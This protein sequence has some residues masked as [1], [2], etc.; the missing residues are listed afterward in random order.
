MVTATASEKRIVIRMGSQTL[1][2]R[3]ISVKVFVGAMK[4]STT[5]SIWLNPAPAACPSTTALSLIGAILASKIE[6]F[7]LA[8]DPAAPGTENLRW[9][10]VTSTVPR[11]EVIFDLFDNNQN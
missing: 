6:K 3:R 4:T 9:R 10:I 1:R 11:A 8:E 5:R 2:L 7:G